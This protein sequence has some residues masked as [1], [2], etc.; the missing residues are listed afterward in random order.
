MIGFPL[1]MFRASVQV[2]A[3]DALARHY[4]L[5]FA[6]SNLARSFMAYA[7]ATHRPQIGNSPQRPAT[8]HQLQ[9]KSGSALT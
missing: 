1:V 2:P 4:G 5:S 9:H 6:A 8:V 3:D 7:S